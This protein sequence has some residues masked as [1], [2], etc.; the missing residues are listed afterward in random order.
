MRES[1]TSLGQ[2]NAAVQKEFVA[3]VFAG[4]HDA[5]R[6]LAHHD[7]ALHEGSG[8]PFAGTYRGADGFI[9]FLGI[10]MATFDIKRLEQTGSFVSEDPDRMAFQFELEAEFRSAHRVFSS[11]LVEVWHFK[12]GKV[13][14]IF[15]HYFN[16]PFR[17]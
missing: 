1:M 14:S 4:D 15:A 7:F 6:R 12:D 13:L 3:A 2:L 16:S 5:L 9:A 8:L 11:S 17:A 10:F